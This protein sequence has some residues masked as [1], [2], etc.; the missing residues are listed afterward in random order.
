MQ[1][2][3]IIAHREVDNV[4]KLAIKLKKY[5]AVYIHFD[6]KCVLT[7]EQKKILGNNEIMWISEVSVNWGSW[8]IGD[9]AV[10]LFKLALTDT[11]NSYFHL[12][13]GQDW[14]NDNLEKLHDFYEQTDKIY[15][16]YELAKETRITGE[17]II[18]WQQFY[19]NYDQIK[20]RTNFGKLYHRLLLGIQLLLRVNKFKRLGI[21]LDIY[22]GAN[23]VDIPRDA[24]E[25]SINY[26]DTHPNFVRM[27]ETGCFSDEF[28]LQTILCNSDEYKNRIVRDNKRYVK[29][30]RQNDS[31]PAV[32]DERDFDNLIKSD[33]YFAR[34]FSEKYSNTL[35]DKLDRYYRN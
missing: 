24:L 13:S 27:L 5:F 17:K 26:M 34:K 15:M 6:K 33:T 8:S 35:L 25:Y 20:R 3:L 22:H 31:W 23:W 1:A 11:N 32:L 21:D 7:E 4:L 9:V 2:V 10:R 16:S 14:P 30:E 18:W 12:I 19:Y 28:W 29:W